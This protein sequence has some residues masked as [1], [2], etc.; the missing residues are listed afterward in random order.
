MVPSEIDNART[1]RG[2][3]FGTVAGEFKAKSRHRRQPGDFK[4]NKFPGEASWTFAGLAVTTRWAW[5]K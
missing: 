2:V 1:L 4:V 5:K 3:V